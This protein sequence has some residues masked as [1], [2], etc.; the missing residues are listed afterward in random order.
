LKKL[1]ISCEI[2]VFIIFLAKIVTVGD[3][4]RNPEAVERYFSVTQALADSPE[5]NRLKPQVQDVSEDSLLKER[6]L[7]A[8]LL[9]KR[10]ELETRE[11]LLKANEKRLVSLKD[12]ILSKIDKLREMETKLTILVGSVNKVDQKR[13]QDLAKVY[14]SAPPAQASSMLEKMDKKTAAAIIMNMR[15]KKAGAIW[16]HINPRKAVE[17]TR[18][19]TKIQSFSKSSSK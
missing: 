18:E 1:I 5:I 9:E 17:I 19:I 3:I 8:S 4:I 2:L 11:N 12:E 15:S 14:E 10:K 13:Y 7:M 16:G 6:E